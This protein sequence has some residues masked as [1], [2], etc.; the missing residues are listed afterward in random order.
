MEEKCLTIITTYIASG[1]TDNS[2][3]DQRIKILQESTIPSL[4]EQLNKNFIW[5]VYLD[6]MNNDPNSIKKIIKL[7]NKYKKMI[8]IHI[9]KYKPIL[10]NGSLCLHNR[11][12]SCSSKRFELYLRTIDYCDEKGYLKGV[13]F[14]SHLMLDDDDP[15]LNT[16]IDW[17]SNKVYQLK[18]K[19]KQHENSNLPK[20]MIVINKNQYIFYLSQMALKKVKSTK[21]LKGSCFIFYHISMIKEIKFHP[22][23]ILEKMENNTV[24]K[25]KYNIDSIILEDEPTW[26]YLRHHVSTSS[27]SKN[28]IVSN[29]IKSWQ[30]EKDIVKV[31]KF[32]THDRLKK[33]KETFRSEVK[34]RDIIEWKNFRNLD[35][36]KILFIYSEIKKYKC[37]ID[38]PNFLKNNFDI[39]TIFLD[40]DAMNY[41]EIKKHDFYKK[42]SHCQSLSC[43]RG[44]NKGIVDN[45]KRFK[46]DYTIIFGDQD[47]MGH[48][49]YYLRRNSYIHCTLNVKDGNHNIVN[50][51]MKNMKTWDSNDY[52]K[53]YNILLKQLNI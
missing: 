37:C 48:L 17:V 53:L 2:F 24:Y 39:F 36:K 27:Y 12:R 28:Y 10:S 50:N 31:L 34:S 49:R 41:E 29:I 16:H 15:I 20:G 33:L 35:K 1:V 45:I 43:K 8:N 44:V 46:P 52:L 42:F 6:E 9:V 5:C 3:I 11:A 30:S 4:I 40:D 19:I 38:I 47:K 22:Y 32:Y 7:L 26:V 13:Q 23:S 51:K 21:A 18:D 14:V 25:D